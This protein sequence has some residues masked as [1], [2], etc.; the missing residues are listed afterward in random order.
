MISFGRKCT[1]TSIG[2]LI[3]IR[4]PQLHGS[5]HL[6]R[7]DMVSIHPPCRVSLLNDSL[8]LNSCHSRNIIEKRYHLTE[9]N[10]ANSA[11]YLLAGPIVLYPLVSHNFQHRRPTEPMVASV[12]VPCRLGEASACCYSAAFSVFVLDHVRVC[13][14]RFATK[15]DP[16]T[17]SGNYLFRSWSR[18]LAL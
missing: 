12:W 18:I 14:V 4:V 13:V 1:P 6:L 3:V 5:Q 7:N 2:M 10:A 8:A 15:L 11:S 16:V 17:S 9:E